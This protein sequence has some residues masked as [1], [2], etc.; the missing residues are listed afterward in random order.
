[1]RGPICRKSSSRRGRRRRDRLTPCEGLERYNCVL[2]VIYQHTS[3]LTTNESDAMFV[4]G[5]RETLQELGEIDCEVA[6]A[7]APTHSLQC[8]TT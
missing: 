8:T 3:L 2:V 7:S 5:D 4:V 1:M 6:R